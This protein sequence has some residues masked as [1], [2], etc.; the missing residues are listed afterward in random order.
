MTKT[1]LQSVYN[2]NKK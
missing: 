1:S 2:K